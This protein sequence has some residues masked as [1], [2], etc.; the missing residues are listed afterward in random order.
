M[1]GWGEF[2]K[3]LYQGED[4]R[5]THQPF[6]GTKKQKQMSS[7]KA[8]SVRSEQVLRSGNLSR[9]TL[10]WVTAVDCWKQVLNQAQKAWCTRRKQSHNLRRSCDTGMRSAQSGDCL[11]AP[12]GARICKVNHK[13]IEPKHWEQCARVRRYREQHRLT[14]RQSWGSSNNSRLRMVN[15]NSQKT[16]PNG[17]WHERYIGMPQ[18]SY[19]LGRLEINKLYCKLSETMDLARRTCGALDVCCSS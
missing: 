14:D 12:A 18:R 8:S 16:L 5:Y 3:D 15:W 4:K 17:I 6:Y 1:E 10:W 11:L 2:Q 9:L 19:F 7:T 13:G